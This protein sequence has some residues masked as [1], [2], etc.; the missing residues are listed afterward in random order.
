MKKKLYY[1]LQLF[2]TIIICP[3]I[4]ILAYIF[5]NFIYLSA[6]II[7]K[8]ISKQNH[9]TYKNAK[10]ESKPIIAKRVS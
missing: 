8:I 9:K 10:A 2:W 1:I 5:A 7:S 6:S 4:C 3:I